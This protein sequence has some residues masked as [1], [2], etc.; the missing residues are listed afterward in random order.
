M[1]RARRLL[2]AFVGLVS[3][4]LLALVARVGW[5]AAD[6][7]RA[8]AAA[9][10]RQTE[11]AAA[12]LAAR[13]AI[14]DRHGRPLAESIATGQVVAWTPRITHDGSR[15]RSAE[16]VLASVET[17]S[18]TLAPLVGVP[19]ESIAEQ[20]VARAPDGTGRNVRIGPRLHDPDALDRIMT[21]RSPTG[22]LRRVDL[23]L[24]WE[25]SHPFGA[26]G[27]AL[28][29][30]VL[31]DG[32]GGAGLEHG[33]Q[34]T[35]GG[36]VDG[37]LP[38]LSG[39]RGLKLFDLDRPVLAPLDGLDVELTIDALLQQMVEQ[40]LAAGCRRLS[41]PFGSA[42]LLD[43]ES[44]DVLAMAS[45]P[46]LDPGDPKTWT[47]D[48]QVLRPLQSVYSPGST[49]KPLML[50]AALELGLVQ[51]DSV[52][53]C[54]PARGRIPGRRKLVKD[55]HPVNRSLDLVELMVR[56]SNVG[57]ANILT[58]LV[59]ED[60]PK[61]TAAMKPLHDLLL[62]LGLAQKTGLPVA[63]E[64]A[65]LL[66]PLSSW[67]R[68][69][70]LVSLSF[71]HEIAVTPLQMAAA[72]ATLADG[73]WRAPRLLAA[74]REGDGRRVEFPIAEPR[75]V[76][77]WETAEFL[78]ECMTAVIAQ[79]ESK[80][81]GFPDLPIAGKTGTTVDERDASK[82]T[83]SF[84][85][86]VP[87]HRPRLCLVVAVVNPKGHRY[88]AGSVAPITAAILRQVVPYFGLTAS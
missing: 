80:S 16:S 34:A 77:S 85:A 60:R 84:V 56:S 10:D 31:A 14:L 63:A 48:A 73:T 24:G 79:G 67:S 43:I 45:Y 55:T 19:A 18:T 53:D 71:G 88:A 22:P 23:E 27:G 2:M 44:G 70:S 62:R 74:V 6:P 81:A 17:I 29:G 54:S 51:R 36:G 20:L 30:F 25:R 83:H 4:A 7:G 50:A 76:F 5:L 69:Y 68:P 39:A 9:R 28:L 49:F 65:G 40:E 87:A 64:S 41:A 26:T 13:G 8:A 82:E 75:P 21:L 42:V 52:V 1:L 11:G 33:L 61:D 12:L 46:T 72:T 66:T 32:R 58:R 78:R 86:L 15:P 37:R 3:L 35:L 47:E 38:Y 57:M 59:P